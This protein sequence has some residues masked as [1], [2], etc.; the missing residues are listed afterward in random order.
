[1]ST[2][3]SWIALDLLPGIGPITAQKLL[4][5]YGN[6]DS[7]FAA[8]TSELRELGLLNKAQLDSLARGPDHNLVRDVI[9]KL[10]SIQARAVCLDDPSYPPILKE[11]HDP[12]CVLYVKGSPDDIQPAVAI[13]GT[14]SPTQYGKDMA[15]RIARGLSSHGISIVSGLARGIDGQ[16]HLGALDGIARTVAVLGSGLD[17]IYPPE[18]A[19]LAERVTAHG[20][21]ISEFPP[22]TSPDARNFPRRNRIIT[23]L[24]QGIVVVEATFR[25]G[26]MISSR[27]ALDQ[28][29]IIMAVPGNVSNARSQGPHQLIRQGA[30]LVQDADD[31][32][33]EIAPQIQGVL[34]ELKPSMNGA[35]DILTL[36]AAA[37][38]SLDEIA[39]Q[40]ELDIVEAS[41]R[42][43]M[44]ELTGAIERI[45]GNRFIV[46]S[47]N[48]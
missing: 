41:R 22:G 15:F 10:D 24:C 9:N 18:H 23:G 19:R 48:G 4:N 43:S 45:E 32:I 8:S 16:A 38:L 40:L 27:Y 34:K 36:V 47:M 30:V 17:I 14:R 12:P 11:I 3:E 39:G 21:L 37:A 20:A 7:I 35:D 31:V 28:G 26:A 2:R 6:P 5:T 1:M 33:S 44:L 42:V 29:K 25:S 13:V 46:R